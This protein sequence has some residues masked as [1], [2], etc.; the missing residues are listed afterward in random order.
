[1]AQRWAE[2]KLAKAKRQRDRYMGRHERFHDSERRGEMIGQPC[3]M[4]EH[5][6]ETIEPLNHVPVRRFPCKGTM[7][8]GCMGA[9]M[10]K[11]R[12][13]PVKLWTGTDGSKGRIAAPPGK[14]M[15][16]NNWSRSTEWKIVTP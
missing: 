13:A 14:G 9:T 1:M 4:P 2:Q 3:P 16:A 15:L 10:R 12:H 5:K 11:A 8:V 7:P 6:G